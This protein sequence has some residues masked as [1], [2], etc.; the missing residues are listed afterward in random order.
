[1]ADAEVHEVVESLDRRREG[2]LGGERADVHLVDGGDAGRALP[3]PVAP[4][5][6]VVVVGAAGGVDAPGLVA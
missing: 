2:A 1:M 5:V 6:A 4:R 3:R